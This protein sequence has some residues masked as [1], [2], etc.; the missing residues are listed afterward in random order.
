MRVS[1]TV[2]LLVGALMISST[3]ASKSHVSNKLAQ[4]SDSTIHA[5]AHGGDVAPSGD[6]HHNTNA[7]KEFSNDIL[8]Q[9]LAN[10][11][12]YAQ[13]NRAQSGSENCPYCDPDY[14]W[15]CP[16]CTPDEDTMYDE[17]DP[18]QQLA[19]LLYE[20]ADYLEMGADGLSDADWAFWDAGTEILNIADV[21]S[22]IG[23]CEGCGGCPGCCGCW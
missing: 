18:T 20:A 16:W 13:K 17:T 4:E 21:I 23:G 15:E 6:H 12:Q 5:P 9:N 10:I 22:E 1:M 11:I 14:E 3:T 2:L 8:V 7:Q 19:N